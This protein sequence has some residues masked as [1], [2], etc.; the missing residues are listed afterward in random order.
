MP[1]RRMTGKA[2]LAGNRATSPGII[3]H[4]DRVGLLRLAR[5]VEALGPQVGLDMRGVLEERERGAV[6][7]ES[8]R[9]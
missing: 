6:G 7:Q 2:S 5:L 1:C 3:L 8:W 4:I 9:G